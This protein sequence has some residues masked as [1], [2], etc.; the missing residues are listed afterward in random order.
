[1]NTPRLITDSNGNAVW[2]WDSSDPFG[3]NIPN[4]SPNGTGNQ[5]VFN[6]RFAGQYYDQETGTYYNGFRNYD[7]VTRRY[8]ESD[9]IGLDGGQFSTYAYAGGNPIR[10]RD[11][12]GLYGM[13]NFVDDAA[14]F[15]A[16]WGDELSFGITAQIRNGFDIGSVNKCSLAYKG[17][18]VAGFANGI[19][20]GWAQGT[21]A[22]A[23]AMSPTNWSNFS[24]SL[25]PKRFLKQFDNDLAEWL[26]QVGNRLNG[27]FIPAGPR[28]DLHDLMDGTAAGIGGSF[29]T[30]PA[31]RQLIN[32]I[33]YVPGSAAYGGASAAANGCGCE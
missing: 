11:P 13:D 19:A 2:Q 30:W 12:Y 14:D 31:W 26:N 9:P 5:F 15:S 28:P 23:K 17:G 33:P 6:L 10:F 7:P 1:L 25:F 22:A 8:L 32:R 21:K 18:K 27:D 4:Q 24:H 3:D 20:I 29:E 16:G